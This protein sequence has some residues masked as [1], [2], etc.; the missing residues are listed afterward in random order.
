MKVKEGYV[1]GCSQPKGHASGCYFDRRIDDP[2]DDQTNAPQPTVLPDPERDTA[3]AFPVGSFVQEELDARGWTIPDLAKRMGGDAKINELAVEIMI[4]CWD[5]PSLRLGQETAEKLAQAFGTSPGLFIGLD[6]AYRMWRERMETKPVTQNEPSS[7][8]IAYQSDAQ[9]AQLAVLPDHD[10][11]ENKVHQPEVVGTITATPVR[12]SSDSIAPVGL[13]KRE[14]DKK[15]PTDEEVWLAN[16]NGEV[17]THFF[18]PG[19]A[20]YEPESAAPVGLGMQEESREFCPHCNPCTHD[21]KGCREPYGD[22]GVKWPYGRPESAASVQPSD[23]GSHRTTME[24]KPNGND[25]SSNGNTDEEGRDSTLARSDALHAGGAQSGSCNH[26]DEKRVIESGGS[27]NRVAASVGSGEREAIEYFEVHRPLHPTDRRHVDALI[28]A[29]V[30]SVRYTVC[31]VC[32]DVGVPSPAVDYRKALEE[33]LKVV[34]DQAEDEVLWFQAET[35][36][37]AFL[38]IALRRLHHAVEG[39]SLAAQAPKDATPG[40]ETERCCDGE[41]SHTNACVR[42]SRGE[43]CF[44]CG[45][46]IGKHRREGEGTCH[47]C[48]PITPGGAAFDKY[49]EWKD[50]P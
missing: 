7:D 36:P 28:A 24:I 50:R 32:A 2:L 9:T 47:K 33:A 35:A 17:I 27:T 23:G 3:E 31:P 16:R 40:D 30:D 49:G 14:E 41:F 26:N 21:G 13:G 8:S 46:G 39:E 43:I 20:L 34:A 1:L 38:Q 15:E 42:R 44:Y 5:E 18:E 19:G 48:D 4:H 25:E 11:W 22:D 6:A 10:D 45:A 37:E 29:A 12:A